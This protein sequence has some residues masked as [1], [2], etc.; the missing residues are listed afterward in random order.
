[1][2]N[3]QRIILDTALALFRALGFQAV[4]VDR[5][6]AE[7]G[8]AKMT[9]YKYFPSKNALIEAVLSE[10]GKQF[11][12]ALLAFVH[13]SGSP[14]HKLRA[15]FHW[16]HDWFSE[17]SFHGCMFINAAVEFPAWKP[18]LERIALEH[19]AH[20][21]Q[22][23]ADILVEFLPA[24]QSADALSLQLRQLLDGAIVSAQ[25]GS[26]P[27]AAGTAWKT[28]VALLKE[29]GVTMEAGGAF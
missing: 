7:A 25:M 14:Q 22:L 11:Q 17:P 18:S 12:A 13:Q 5:V 1:M 3:K 10:R 2:K 27:Q 23:L 28:A 6:V 15:V 20:I 4:G 16:H 9:L 19:K 29:N 26:D 21:Q 24:E 8:V